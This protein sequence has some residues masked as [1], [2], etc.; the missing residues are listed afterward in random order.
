MSIEKIYQL[1]ALPD[2]RYQKTP[3]TD[4]H[5][6]SSDADTKLIGIL[7]AMT[8]IGNSI[9]DE[10]GKKHIDTVAIENLG[11][12]VSILSEVAIFINQISSSAH[13]LSGIKDGSGADANQ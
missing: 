6:I 11:S 5:R 4:Y 1:D 13:Y 10:A 9:M 8:F 3:E 2:F 12:I 7:D